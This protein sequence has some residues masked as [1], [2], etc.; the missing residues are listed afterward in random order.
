MVS[1]AFDAVNVEFGRVLWHK[2]LYLQPIF[3]ALNLTSPYMEGKFS[4]PFQL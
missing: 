1:H 3:K 4:P 2:H